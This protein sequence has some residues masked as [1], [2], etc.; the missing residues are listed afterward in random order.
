[1]YYFSYICSVQTLKFC[2]MSKINFSVTQILPNGKE[3]HT[4]LFKEEICEE[5]HISDFQPIL[6]FIQAWLSS[7]LMVSSKF[8]FH[9]E[10]DFSDR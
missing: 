4:V 8:T 5:I 7:E 9:I 1:M 10:Y 2:I 6:P 3:E